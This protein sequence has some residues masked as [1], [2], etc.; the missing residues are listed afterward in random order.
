MNLSRPLDALL[1]L[2]IARELPDGMIELVVDEADATEGGMI[3]ISMRVDLHCDACNAGVD[4]SCAKC[5]GSRVLDE[6]YSAWLALRP[7]VADGTVLRP[8]AQLP[9]VIREVM[10]R[11]R[12][13]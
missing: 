10:F 1:A 3:R 12:R 6:T 9:G 2:G 11:V 5:G 4:Q 8:S 13:V 7:G